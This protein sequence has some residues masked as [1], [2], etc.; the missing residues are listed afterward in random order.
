MATDDGMSPAT[1]KYNHLGKGKLDEA[2]ESSDCYK[3]R[4]AVAVRR[5]KRAMDA[6]KEEIKHL[7]A[8]LGKCPSS[9]CCTWGSNGLTFV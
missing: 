9:M 8:H 6:V 4:S 1:F 5:A 2:C 3:R 7:A